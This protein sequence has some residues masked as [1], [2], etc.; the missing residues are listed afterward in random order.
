MLELVLQG[1][2]TRKY[3]TVLPA[4]AD[5]GGGEQVGGLAGDHQ[6]GDAGSEGVGRTGPA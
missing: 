1:V 2:S 3:E 4:M 5:A 6:G